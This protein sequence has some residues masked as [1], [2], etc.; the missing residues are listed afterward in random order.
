MLPLV[1][2]KTACQAIQRPTKLT[3]RV[4]VAN[5][6]FSGHGGAQEIVDQEAQDEEVI[7]QPQDLV[8]VM[9]SRADHVK[10]PTTLFVTVLRDFARHV[11]QGA[12]TNHR[13][14]ALIISPD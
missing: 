10:P 6:T 8:T 4:D 7:H 1:G 13:I 12:M 14:S 9:G 11:A 5:I 2:L 3:I